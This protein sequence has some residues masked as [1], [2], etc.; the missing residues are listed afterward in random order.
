[1]IVDLVPTEDQQAIAEGVSQLLQ[2]VL[3]VSRLREEHAHG[4]RAEKAQWQA[5][6]ELGLFGLGIAE[7]D[8]GMGLGLPEELLAARAMGENLLSPSILA[9]AVAG[10][11]AD[12]SLRA[13]IASG[14][15]RIAFA[16][17][18]AQGGALLLDSEDAEYILFLDDGATLLPREALGEIMP[19]AG[20]DETISFARATAPSGKA[21]DEV[22][23]RISLLIAAYLVG[24]AAASTD[25]AVE[26]ARTREQFGQ[27]IGGFQAIKHMCADMAARAAGADAQVRHAAI[28]FGTGGDDRR[29]IA[30]GRL[31]AGRAALANAKANIQIHGGM[32]YT[33]ECDAHLFLKRAH[34][35]SA[36]GSTARA[37]ERRII[38]A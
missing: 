27:P 2:D 13:S 24:A 26:Y 15:T 3:P 11:V 9:Q 38:P 7:A 4:A 6:S 20:L 29:E 23:D 22:A 8:G 12:P 34:V 32:G 31:L 36:L 14:E 17:R 33:A 35:M 37:E 30:A 16:T 1:M 5:L 10:H 21:R 18:T 25:M 19:I 28:T